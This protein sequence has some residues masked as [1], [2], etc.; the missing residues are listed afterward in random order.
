MST[1]TSTSPK[2]PRC[3][4]DLPADAVAGLCPRCLMAGAITMPVC[5]LLMAHFPRTVPLFSVPVLSL[6]LGG[7]LT[8][9]AVTGVL[10]A[11]GL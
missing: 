6:L 8:T 7:L 2:C 5:C 4:A 11:T 9:I 10:K 3:N 1:T